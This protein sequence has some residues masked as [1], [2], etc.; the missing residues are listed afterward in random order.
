MPSFIYRLLG[1]KRDL[2]FGKSAPGT[3]RKVIK[4]LSP[5]VGKFIMQLKE[6]LQKFTSQTKM[7]EPN[8]YE[9][10]FNRNTTFH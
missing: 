4:K 3:V 7:S 6:K 8:F 5:F 1:E 10:V 9:V 2:G